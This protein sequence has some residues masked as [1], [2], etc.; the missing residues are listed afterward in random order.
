MEQKTA[1]YTASAPAIGLFK[2]LEQKKHQEK[3][4]ASA[5]KKRMIMQKTRSILRGE[6][7][8]SQRDLS[9]TMVETALSTA[10]SQV[11]SKLVAQFETSDSPIKQ[12]GTHHTSTSTAV[13]SFICH[14]H[15]PAPAKPKPK[16]GPV[17]EKER[18]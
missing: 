11:V 1:T 9:S 12:P 10:A 14:L 15:L 8:S 5:A 4:A 17:Y 7:M 16:A 6:S 13:S 18:K 2:K 3:A